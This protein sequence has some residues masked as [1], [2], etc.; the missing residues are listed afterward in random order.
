MLVAVLCQ[1]RQFVGDDDQ[2]RRHRQLLLQSGQLGSV[3][4]QRGV[5][6]AAGGQSHHVGSDVR[7]AVAVAADPGA[8]PQDGF[9]QQ[10][11]VGPPTA[12]RL[13][14]LGVDLWHHLEERGLVVAEPDGD[15]VGDLQPGQ[16]NQRGLPQRQ[17]LAAQFQLDVAAVVG[18]G[19]P[20]RAQPHQLGDPVLGVEHR[21]STGFRRVGGDHRGDQRAGQC[22]G[23]GRRVQLR[24]VELQIG[25]GQAAVLRRVARSHVDGATPFPVNVLGDVGQQ[26]EV[27]ER[28]DH[29]DR[30]MDIDALERAGHLGAFDFRAT[31]PKRLNPGTLDQVEDLVA[32]LLAHRVAED[33][34]Q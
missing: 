10:V 31:Y 26:R 23:D 28:P 34:A 12:Q 6:G 3:V 21:S 24:R 2:S 18:F 22:V 13:P 4:T 29:R 1:C 15:L 7:V 25:G 8:G 14:D 16:P 32:V 17:H 33:G 19:A 9:G 20:V 30:L 11:G 27:A 5:G